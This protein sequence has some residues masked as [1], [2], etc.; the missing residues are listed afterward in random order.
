[1][2][3]SY[4]TEQQF[5]LLFCVSELPWKSVTLSYTLEFCMYNLICFLISTVN[6]TLWKT[7][8]YLSLISTQITHPIARLPFYELG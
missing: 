8:M 3:K 7:F 5:I 2:C 4:F 1:M 6:H